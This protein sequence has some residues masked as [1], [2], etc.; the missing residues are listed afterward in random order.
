MQ[1]M[2]TIVPRLCTCSSSAINRIP[3]AVQN[4]VD[5][6]PNS[7]GS[8]MPTL[9]QVVRLGKGSMENIHSSL[10]QNLIRSDTMMAMIFC[11]WSFFFQPTKANHTCIVVCSTSRHYAWPRLHGKVDEYFLSENVSS[12][13][14]TILVESTSPQKS[15]SQVNPK[16][17]LGN[18]NYR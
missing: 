13:A 5:S 8:L 17:F 11:V 15:F 14:R 3:E 18:T 4:H 12:M 10:V 16:K 7:P 1:R 9:L 6:H 2:V